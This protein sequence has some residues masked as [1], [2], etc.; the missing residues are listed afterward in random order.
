M[1]CTTYII[2]ELV[3]YRFILFAEWVQ[4]P[5]RSPPHAYIF[6]NTLLLKVGRISKAVDDYSG[7]GFKEKKSCSTAGFPKA[8]LY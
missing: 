6:H 4:S 7:L 1:V 2:Q 5:D 8:L 3:Y